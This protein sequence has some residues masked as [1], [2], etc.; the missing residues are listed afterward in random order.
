MSFNKI[1][2]LFAIS[3][4]LACSIN[5]P[6]LPEWDTDWKIYLPTQDFIMGE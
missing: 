6:K 5:E 1:I 2:T 4:L 3:F